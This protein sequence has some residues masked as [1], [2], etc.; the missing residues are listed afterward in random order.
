[1]ASIERVSDVVR[2]K[3]HGVYGIG[4]DAS[5]REAAQAFLDKDVSALVVFSGD[6]VVG[7]FTKN[8]L[9]RQYLKRTDEFE[10]KTVGQC[11]TTNFFSTT[12]D[13]NLD[14]LFAEMLRRGVRHVPVFEGTRPI[15]MIT[16]LDILVHQKSSVE[17]ENEQLM[18]YIHGKHYE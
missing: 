5:M 8:D 7:V 4:K 15:G 18:R 9:L 10:N 17:F 3:G 16:S 13:V 6:E 11:A 12:P 2:L 1:M 14:A